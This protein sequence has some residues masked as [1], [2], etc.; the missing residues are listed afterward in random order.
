MNNAELAQELWSLTSAPSGVDRARLK[1]VVDS[2]DPSGLDARTRELFWAS[3]EALSGG[4]TSQTRFPSLAMR[5]IEPMRK[6]TIEQFLREMGARLQR[7]TEMIVGGSSA[8]ILQGLLTRNT[9]D[10]DVVDEVPLPI[11]EMHEWRAKAQVRYGLYIAHFQSH[12]LPGGWGERL[13]SAGGFGKLEV[14]L[15]DPTDI[16]VGKLFS[17]REKDLDDLRA[18]APLLDKA[19]IDRR[20][21][22]STALLADEARKELAKENFFI[23]FGEDL[24]LV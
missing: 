21:A 13:Q 7:P 23:V 4:G 9:E 22:S 3:R 20:L 10:V 19:K 17:R 1:E 8:L 6:S 5:I 15:V 18:L 12:Y 14:A 24:P 2:L 16:F 11:R